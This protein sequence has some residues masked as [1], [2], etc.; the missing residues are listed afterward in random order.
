MKIEHIAWQ[1]EDPEK[2][3][4]WYCE[5][6]GMRVV[7]RGDPKAGAVFLA[8]GL[9]KTVIEIYRNKSVEVPDYRKMDP[10]L[11]HIAFQVQDVAAKTV[12]LKKAGAVLVSGPDNLENGDTIAM[13]RDPWG[14]PLQLVKR[15]EPMMEDS[16]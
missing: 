10:L 7:R 3:V 16:V 14:L 1:T 5:N 11:L 2:M 9:G 8:D 15:A 13:I 12:R 4:E 6:L